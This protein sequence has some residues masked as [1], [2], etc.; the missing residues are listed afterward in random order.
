MKTIEELE[1]EVETVIDE[2]P[3]LTWKTKPSKGQEFGE[4][5]F[6]KHGK[7][8]KVHDF[9]QEGREDTEIYP[10]LEKYGSIKKMQ[11]ESEL[12]FGDATQIKDLAGAMKIVE[13]GQKRW[14]A[15]SLEDRLIFGN[16]KERFINEGEQWVKNKIE[17]IKQEI[18][19]K[20]EVK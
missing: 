4:P 16:D 12:V 10:T 3:F 8:I 5:T 17:K 20:E 1:K 13:E 11:T 14:Q 7:E 15:M 18:K 2:M 6:I 19:A 9:I